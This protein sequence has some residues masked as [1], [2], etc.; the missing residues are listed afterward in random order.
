MTVKLTFD[1]YFNFCQ[2]VPFD[3]GRELVEFL[4][5]QLATQLAM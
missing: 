2:I 4:K 5:S 3:N 1:M